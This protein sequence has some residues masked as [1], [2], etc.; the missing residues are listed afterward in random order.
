MTVH[1]YNPSTQEFEASLDY[2][3]RTCPPTPKKTQKTVQ[4]I[5]SEPA[6]GWDVGWGQHHRRSER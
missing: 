1:A 5:E 3:G 6:E 4:Q 2:V